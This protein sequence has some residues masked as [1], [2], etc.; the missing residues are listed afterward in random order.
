MKVCIA[1]KND[2]AIFNGNG[3]SSV[4]LTK[5]VKVNKLKVLNA[6]SGTINLDGFQL[7][8]TK[9]PLIAGGKVEVNGGFLQAWGWTYIQSGGEVD[10]SASGSRIKIGH[11]ISIRNGATLTAPDGDSSRFIVKG[12]F[13][14]ESG[15][16]FY[17]NSG[18]VTMTTKWNAA[19]RIDDGPGT[20]RNFY[21]LHKTG[22]RHAT[23]TTND[24]EVKN[25]V[26]II[27]TGSIKAQSNNITVGARIEAKTDAIWS[28]TENGASLY[29]Y[30]TDGDAS[31]GLA[32][33]LDSDQKATFAGQRRFRQIDD[34]QINK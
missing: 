24:I 5:Y 25:D 17:H 16:V 10:A 3:L 29:F 33:T 28:D 32:L 34:V 27:G 31:Q 13:N 15:G 6:Y 4:K 21:N 7:A 1:G 8:S 12:G 20:G 9:G 26:T 18:T 23:L 30:T 19:I 22:P 11:N 14:I 2:I